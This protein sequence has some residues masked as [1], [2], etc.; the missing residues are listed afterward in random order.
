MVD[1]ESVPSA[2]LIAWTQV[3]PGNEPGRGD[4]I[5]PLDSFKNFPVEVHHLTEPRCQLMEQRGQI[6]VGDDRLRNGQQSLVLMV[7]ERRLCV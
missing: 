3:I 2:G 6:A 4:S 5:R 1:A 7:R